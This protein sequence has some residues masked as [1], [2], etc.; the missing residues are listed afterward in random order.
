[1]EEVIDE[2]EKG[3]VIKKEVVDKKEC[4]KNLEHSEK[5][6]I[7]VNGDMETINLEDDISLEE[8]KNYIYEEKLNTGLK[9][10]DIGCGIFCS[11][12]KKICEYLCYNLQKC[13]EYIKN[14]CKDRINN[15]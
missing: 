3:E 8:E 13:S 15:N 9:D 14:K 10:V 11:G 2:V 4:K 7:M 5:I 6:D 1:M 12:C